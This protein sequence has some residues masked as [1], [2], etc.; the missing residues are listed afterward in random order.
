MVEEKDNRG[1]KKETGKRMKGSERRR[2]SVITPVS[3]CQAA[4]E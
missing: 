3:V 2:V 4:S 1:D